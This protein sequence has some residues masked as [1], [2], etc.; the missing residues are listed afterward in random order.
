LLS[1]GA[2]K[3]NRWPCEVAAETPPKTGFCGDSGQ[4]PENISATNM[5]A[6]SLNDTFAPPRPLCPAALAVFERHV[7]RIYRE[8]R[9]AAIDTELLAVFAESLT[10]Y[11]AFWQDVENLGTLIAGRDGGMVKNPSLS[12]LHTVRADLIRLSRAIPL[13]THKADNDGAY[14][15]R[16]LQEV[17]TG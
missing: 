3:P 16:L 14:V 7:A 10:L 9:W 4:L 1:P 17:M 8:G 5:G 2:L 15:D 6:S 13:F 11:Q 12:G